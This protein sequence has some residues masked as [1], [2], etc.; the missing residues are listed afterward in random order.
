[1]VVWVSLRVN[2]E[3]QEALVSILEIEGLTQELS[4]TPLFTGFYKGTRSI[5]LLTTWPLFLR[6]LL[7]I[8]G[9]WLLTA[10]LDPVRIWSSCMIVAM[11]L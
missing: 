7:V 4:I 3:I 2:P 8:E 11:E 5:S 1:M 9:M 10:S 6:F